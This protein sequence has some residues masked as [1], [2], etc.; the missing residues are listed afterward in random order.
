M[1]ATDKD[2]EAEEEVEGVR[3]KG[4][5]RGEGENKGFRQEDQQIFAVFVTSLY[6]FI[7]ACLF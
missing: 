6:G 4:R 7:V 2:A 3:G 1:K 5:G